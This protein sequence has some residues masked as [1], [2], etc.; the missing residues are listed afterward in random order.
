MSAKHPV[1]AV[2]GSSGA[3]TT[4]TSLAFRKY[5]AVKSACS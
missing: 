3:G 1:I 4:T 2:T 5:R